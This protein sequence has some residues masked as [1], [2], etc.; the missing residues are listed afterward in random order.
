ML[1]KPAWRTHL[2]MERKAFSPELRS[3]ANRK[4]TE[5]FLSLP[6]WQNA[7]SVGC[8]LALPDEVQ[9]SALIETGLQNGKIMAAPVTTH[10]SE[11]M[12]FYQ[13]T[14]C[15][16]LEPGPLGIPQPPR[17][18][19]LPPDKIDLLV[20]PGVGFDLLGYRLGYGGGFYD[21]YLAN[22]AGITLGLAFDLQVT[23]RLPVV[24]YDLPVQILVT[25]SRILH[26]H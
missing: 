2:F 14:S 19:L 17:D 7:R 9:T 25:E 5:S 4:I 22:F 8:Y 26:F 20:I 1:D 3:A 18:C 15:Q 16:N 10:K 24:S 13:L 11:P 23:E 21:H 12:H 6:E